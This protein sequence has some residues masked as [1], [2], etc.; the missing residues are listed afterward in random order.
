M[1]TKDNLSSPNPRRAFFK[2][3]A[4][5]AAGTVAAGGILP[6]ALQAAEKRADKKIEAKPHPEAVKRTR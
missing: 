6:K 3:I 4:A 1:S 5:V 2:K